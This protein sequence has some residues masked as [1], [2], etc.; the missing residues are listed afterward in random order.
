V[1]TLYEVL[2]WIGGRLDD[3]YGARIGRIEDVFVDHG[4]PAW[5]MV[6]AGRWRN[7][8]VFIRVGDVDFTGGSLN[9]GCHRDEALRS[10]SGEDARR[11]RRWSEPEESKT[12]SW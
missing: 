4:R 5:L 3:R 12:V 11:L 9:V 1:P 10:L 8:Q 2:G 7:R 6:N